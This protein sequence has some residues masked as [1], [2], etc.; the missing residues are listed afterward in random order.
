MKAEDKELLFKFLSE[1]LPYG[2]NVLEDLDKTFD[3]GAIGE[4]KTVTYIHGEPHIYTNHSLIPINMEEIR[5]YLRT[6]SS[7]T[8]DEKREFVKQN[9]MKEFHS[10]D[11]D[12]ILYFTHNCINWLR[13]NHFD[14]MNLIPRG[15]AIAVT[16]KLN[17]YKK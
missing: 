16:E 13:E 8:E 3:G 7:M 1:N 2:L 10:V 11:A 17:P 14:Y 12:C 15:L 4:L 9:C 6:F 5:P